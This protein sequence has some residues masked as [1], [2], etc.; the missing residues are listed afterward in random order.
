MIHAHIA[1]T[2]IDALHVG[3]PA[4]LRF[5]HM[6]QGVTP[7]AEGHI[8]RVSADILHDP[9]QGHAYYR[10]EITL[11]PGALGALPR[12]TSLIPGMPVETFIRTGDHRPAA[13]LVRPIADYF[14]RAFRQ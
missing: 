7:R 3:Q 6:D 11:H 5:P 9:N 8:T 12:G 13:Y 1:P 14:A 10:A 4:T 2:D